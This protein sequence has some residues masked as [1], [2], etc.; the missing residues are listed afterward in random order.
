MSSITPRPSGSAAGRSLA[1][2]VLLVL[3]ACA[4]DLKVAPETEARPLQEAQIPAESQLQYDL[5]NGALRFFVGNPDRMPEDEFERRYAR[6][7]FVVVRT[8]LGTRRFDY[9]EELRGWEWA[10]LTYDEASG[11]IWGFLEHTVAGPGE[12]L[13]VV[14]S[15]DQGLSWKRLP[16][17]PKPHHAARYAGS[18]WKQGRLEVSLAVEADLMPEKKAPRGTRQWSETYVGLDEGRGG[19]RTLGLKATK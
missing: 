2:H 7:P 5:G 13:V 14:A 8:D 4:S 3:G 9:R 19:W 10:G 12:T 15:F 17:V 1:F 16:D 11:K 6:G 18:T